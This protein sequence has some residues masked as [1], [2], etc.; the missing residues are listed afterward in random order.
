MRILLLAGLL[1]LPF[2]STTFAHAL[3]PGYLE[4]EAMGGDTWRAFWKKP[5]VGGAPMPIEAVL[6]DNCTPNRSGSPRFDGAA[7][8]AR[9]LTSCPG[10]LANGIIEIE[11]LDRTETDVLIR[12]E[13]AAGQ[14]EAYRL[15]PEVT[16]FTVPEVPGQ[17][18]VAATYAGLGIEHILAGIDHL[19]F[20]LALLLLIR[21]FWRLV[22]AVT[23]FTV[24]HSL[25]LAAAT[26]GWVV[27]PGPPVEAVI[28]LSIMFL[29]SELLKR[30]A[31]GELRLSERVP[32]IVAFAFGLLHGLGFAGALLE[33]GLPRSDVPLALFAFNLGV[34]AGQLLF[35]GVVLSVW[36]VIRHLMPRLTG[37]RSGLRIA[38]YAIGGIAGFWFVERIAAF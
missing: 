12:Y 32:W 16:S 3:E 36:I 7:F 30:R 14:G 1:L 38:S 17:I 13:L 2:S 24:A 34:E 35:I 26:L 10:G 29:A 33:I 19:L 6:P 22:G 27:I 18:E 11:G 23:A 20:V 15:T 25:T 37:S 9:W 4:L 28:A 5:A 31:G 8:V 21:D